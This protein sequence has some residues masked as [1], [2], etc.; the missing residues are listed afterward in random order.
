MR[1]GRKKHLWPKCKGP[2][3][4]SAPVPFS[5][6]TALAQ[7]PAT[8]VPSAPG[9]D[10][11]LLGKRSPRRCHGQAEKCLGLTR[12]VEFLVSLRKDTCSLKDTSELTTSCAA[13]YWRVT[14][15]ILELPCTC[16][17]LVSSVASCQFAAFIRHTA[18]LCEQLL[19]PDKTC[20]IRTKPY[21]QRRGTSESTACYA[22]TC[23]GGATGSSTDRAITKCLP[24]TTSKLAVGFNLL[25][26]RF[27]S[28]TT[29]LA[30]A[31]PE[32][33]RL[34]KAAHG[35]KSLLPNPKDASTH[36]PCI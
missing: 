28:L 31:L 24:A 12:A 6:G 14:T 25:N 29:C 8:S 7:N 23:K 34:A 17:H 9:L 13:S 30:P 11:A 26:M 32:R 33:G 1:S 10:E 15:Q 27:D 22:L 2:P 16:L 35:G 4:P 20:F 21:R 36:K 3:P 19:Y 18:T 5:N